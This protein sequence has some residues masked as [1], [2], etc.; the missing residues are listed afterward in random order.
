MRP[1]MVLSGSFEKLVQRH[2]AGDPAW[3]RDDLEFGACIE[4]VEGLAVQME[5]E[6]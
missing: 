5:S 1:S 4:T 3:Y 6:R 2:V